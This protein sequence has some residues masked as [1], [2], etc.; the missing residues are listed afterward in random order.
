MSK[1]FTRMLGI[2]F[3][4]AAVIGL[5]FSLFAILSVWRG[6]AAV[7]QVVSDSIQVISNTLTTTGAGLDLAD[8][9]VQTAADAVLSAEI[10]TLSLAQAVNDIDDLVDIFVSL[11]SLGLPGLDNQASSDLQGTSNNLNSTEL[12]MLTLSTNISQASLRLL[13][14]EQLL[15]DYRTNLEQARQQLIYFQD[16]LHKWSRNLAWFLSF[17]LVWLA[18]TQLG[19]L[20]QGL[21]MLRRP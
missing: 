5:A 19:L 9:S 20:S 11:T 18:I 7:D 4:V 13:A 8:Q 2:T 15:S 14:A 3:I 16:N 1:I 17:G 21:Q 10:A 6:R 12:A